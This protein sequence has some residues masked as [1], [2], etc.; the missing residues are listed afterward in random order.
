[1]NSKYVKEL[2]IDLSD[3]E[4]KWKITLN[5]EARLIFQVTA[6]RSEKI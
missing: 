6:S 1:M 4:K 3:V 2:R 5:E